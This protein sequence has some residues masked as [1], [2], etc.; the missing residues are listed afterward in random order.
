[1]PDS[2]PRH[3]TS[4]EN[5]LK[6]N[7]CIARREVQYLSAEPYDLLSIGSHKDKGMAKVGSIVERVAVFFSLSRRKVVISSLH[8]ESVH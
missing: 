4:T 2:I 7:G 3:V 5:W 1:M 8:S 6:M